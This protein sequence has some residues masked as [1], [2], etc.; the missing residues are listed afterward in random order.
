[1]GWN[2]LSYWFRG[3]ISGLLISII[4]FL[5]KIVLTTSE[6]APPIC[7][8]NGG[9]EIIGQRCSAMEFLTMNYL[10]EIISVTILFGIIGWV[11]GKIKNRNT[12]VKE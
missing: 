9:W 7:N 8:Y 11:Y 1:M 5:I 6:S 10:I 12:R 2:D 4:F 3:G